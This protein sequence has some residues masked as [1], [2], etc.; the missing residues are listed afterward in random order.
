MNL[1]FK[2]DSLRQR[3]PVLALIAWVLLLVTTPNGFAQTR[4][5]GL[6]NPTSG[7]PVPKILLL[8]ILRAEDER[9]WDNDLR[10]LFSARNAAVRSRAALAAGRIG[11]ENAVGDLIKLLQRDD[12]PYVRAM[13]AFA[14]GEVEPSSG[15]NALL[16][17]LKDTK[18]PLVRARAVEALGKIAAALPKEQEARAHELGSAIL[19]VLTFEARRSP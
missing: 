3:L 9:R 5:R 18:D 13:A 2:T 8:R 15:T 14:L 1:I 10:D 7:D 4:A 11:D 6:Q 12:E 17:T 19:E 16:T